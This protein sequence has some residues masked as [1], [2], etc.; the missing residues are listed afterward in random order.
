MFYIYIYICC[1]SFSANLLSS[2][3]GAFAICG[4]VLY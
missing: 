4:L 1:I 3:I 2:D